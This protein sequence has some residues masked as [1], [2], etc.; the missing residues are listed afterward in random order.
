MAAKTQ[1][2]S[3]KAILASSKIELMLEV[4]AEIAQNFNKR[5]FS[6]G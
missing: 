2:L 4:V 3:P 5:V 6:Y 1:S